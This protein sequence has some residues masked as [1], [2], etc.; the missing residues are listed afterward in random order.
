MKKPNMEREFLEFL[1]SS[2][3]SPPKGISQHV[4]K[5]ITDDLNPSSPSVFFK[6]GLI[7]LVVGTITLLFCPQFGFGFLN[8]MGI[9]HLFMSLGSFG[10][11]LLCGSI[12]IGFSTL[13]VG[14]ILQPEEIKVVRKNNFIQIS[15]LALLS[16]L[17]FMFFA[18]SIEPG[19]TTAWLLGGILMG[20][21]SLE[22]GWFLRK[23]LWS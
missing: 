22:A 20:V 4:V 12:F 3:V 6:V 7:H 23:H 16:L 18:E 21:L 1:S 2:P 9:M 17:I 10:C 11:A 5:T 13:I 15:L 8:G 19:H 14:F